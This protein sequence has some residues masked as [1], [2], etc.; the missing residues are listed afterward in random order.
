M[1]RNKREGEPGNPDPPGQLNNGHGNR[2]TSRSD[3]SSYGLIWQRLSELKITPHTNGNGSTNGHRGEPLRVT[4][5]M[6]DNNGN[7]LVTEVRI[8]GIVVERREAKPQKKT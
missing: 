4:E 2:S 1:S 7:V 5:R 3:L 8:G 6:Y